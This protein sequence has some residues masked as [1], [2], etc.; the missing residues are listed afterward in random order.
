MGQSITCSFNE[1]KGFGKQTLL[2]VLFVG[3][4]VFHVFIEL[5]PVRLQPL[6]ISPAAY[7]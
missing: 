2:G 6:A 7:C 4:R 1:I 5:L 3:G